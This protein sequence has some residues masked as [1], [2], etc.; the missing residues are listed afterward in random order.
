MP[1]CGDLSD[2]DAA[3]LATADAL[4]ETVRAEMNALAIHKALAAIIALVSEGDRYFAGQEPWALKKTDPARMAA[5][6]RQL[7]DAL[8]AFATVLQPFM[9][10]SMA[11]MLEQLGVPE[12]ARGLA[13]L[14]APLPGGTPLPAPAPLFRKIEEAAAPRGGA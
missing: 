6:L 9:P 12:Q 13:D 7:H 11:T 10:G 14:D 3:I 4:V 5:V 2:A 8:R 1:A